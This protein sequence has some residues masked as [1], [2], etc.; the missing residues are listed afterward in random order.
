MKTIDINCD[1]GEGV[2]N[3]ALLMPYIASC[4]IACGAHA[5]SPET[6]KKTILLAQ[7]YGLKIGAHPSFPNRKNFGRKEMNISSEKLQQSI[8]SQL[9]LIQQIAEKLEAQ[10]HHVKAHGALYNLIAKDRQI[11]TVFVK[12]VQTIFD[13]ILLY[14]PSDSVIEKV[15][16]QHNLKVTHEAFIDRNYNEDKTLVARTQKN[17]LIQNP[18]EAY[19]HVLNMFLN[20]KVKTIT[21]LDK[22][23]KADT[24][25]V[26]GDGKN[27]LDILKFLKKSL[28]EKGIDIA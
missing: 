22:Q 16:L 5:G 27:A 2:H 12:A 19:K 23:I 15:A 28:L 4:N 3:E 17:A 24:F 7:K 11:A 1:V 26:H 6:I 18:K 21:G 20:G 8:V 14:V 13:D 9:Q 25:C 10:I